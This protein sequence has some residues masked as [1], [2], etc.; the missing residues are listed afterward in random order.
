MSEIF[1]VSFGIVLPYKTNLGLYIWWRGLWYFTG[2]IRFKKLSYQKSDPFSE[3]EICRYDKNNMIQLRALVTWWSNMVKTLAIHDLSVY[4]GKISPLALKVM[5]GKLLEKNPVHFPGKNPK[6]FKKY[7]KISKNPK[8]RLLFFWVIYPSESH[9]I[10]FF[11]S[12]MCSPI[13]FW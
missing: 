12:K 7:P 3:K 13:L 1:S 4:T 6:N 11:F 8:C 5:W 2:M 9:V 10:D